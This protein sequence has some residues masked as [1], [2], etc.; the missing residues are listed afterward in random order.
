MGTTRRAYNSSLIS[1]LRYLYSSFGL[2]G[3]ITVLKAKLAG[4]NR[5]LE[6]E[7]PGIRFP[8]FLRCRTSDIATFDQ[9]FIDEEYDCIASRPPQVI[10]DA[11]ANVGLASIYFAN[12]FPEA[13]IFAI[14]P[15]SKNF[16]TLRLNVAPYSNIV[17]LHAALWNKNEEINLLDPG[18]GEWGFVTE[19]VGT[20]PIVRGEV[21]QKVRGVT[22]DTLISEYRLDR[23][24]ILKMD[25][26]GT[27]REVFQDPSA[28][29]GQIEALIVELHDRI[30]PGCSVSFYRWVKE[31]DYEWKQGENVFL[32]RGPWLTRPAPS[33]S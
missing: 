24:D 26:E 11:G 21:C 8:F 12:R 17:P 27:E 33:Q 19:Q 16:E 29:V 6:V 30:K 1:N 13:R 15:E 3:L 31:F 22:V 14:E 25:I 32:T 7:R 23:I 20:E 4:S 2:S 5:L 9:I 18:F 10:L 28:W